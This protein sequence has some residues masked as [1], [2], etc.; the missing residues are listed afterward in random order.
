MRMDGTRTDGVRTDGMRVMGANSAGSSTKEEHLG[1]D[2]AGATAPLRCM[3]RHAAHAYHQQVNLSVSDTGRGNRNKANMAG[4]CFSQRN[5][6]IRIR[7]V[8][9]IVAYNLFLSEED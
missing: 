2:L 9:Q 1:R 6:P 5:N 3:S 4:A 7:R 8:P